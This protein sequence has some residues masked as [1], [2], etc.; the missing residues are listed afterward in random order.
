MKKILFCASFFAIL[1]IL[2]CG[3]SGDTTG[4]Q[5]PNTSYLSSAEDE[6]SD[7]D[8]FSS[9]DFEVSSSS[10]EQTGSEYDAETKILTDL[11]DGK[12][13][14]TVDIGSQTWMAENLNF[15]T[16]NSYCYDKKASNC[17]KYGRLYT[18]AAAMDSAGQWSLNGAGCG[19]DK[20]CS[21]VLPVRGVCPYGWHLPS[22]RELLTLIEATGGKSDAP[23]RL[24]ADSGWCCNGNG[25]DDYAFTALPAGDRESDG[26]YDDIRDNA[27]FWSSTESG[28]LAHTLFLSSFDITLTVFNTFFKDNG[29]SV[30]CL[31]D[32]PNKKSSSSTTV[33][34]SSSTATEHVEVTTGTFTDKRD[35]QTYKTVIIDRQM[36]MA[37]NLNYETEKSFCYN[38]DPA[39]C[40]KYG[41]LYTWGAA[42]D[43]AGKWS[44]NGKNCGYRNWN[45]SPTYP[46]RGIC[47][48]GWHLPDTTEFNRLFFAIGKRAVIGKM[49]KSTSDWNS[50]SEGL[51]SYSFSMLPSGY[52]LYNPDHYGGEGGYA[53]L[54]SSFEAYIAYFDSRDKVE[55]LDF[56][57]D[58]A[59]SVRCLKE[60]PIELLSSSS[61]DVESSSSSEDF[62]S[63]SSAEYVESSSSAEDVDSS[64]SAEDVES[65]SS[66]ED[67]ESSSSAE[68]V[69]SS[70]SAED[71]E[72]SS[73]AEDVDSS[74]SEN[75]EIITGTSSSQAD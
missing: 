62:E 63:S 40:E 55:I 70:S 57:K 26:D 34:S 71:A 43:S 59:F 44:Y 42:M 45:C 64:S 11:R 6:P 20:T 67:V 54:W 56:G 46:V 1:F 60:V 50:G 25:T 7:F 19:Y 65:S 13:Y 35:N 27:F 72:S 74:S 24:K 2:A 3:D 17:E 12:T 22:Y 69:E 41:R 58:K 28:N 16:K 75:G 9:S 18:W 66:A 39:N 51:D 29:F 37:Q 38:N 21:A 10:K 4:L 73:S 32:T 23:A 47:P 15:Q 61:D 30:R 49:L 5:A 8:S 36:W 53:Y 68:D 33:E 52:K 48:E 14:R 31:K